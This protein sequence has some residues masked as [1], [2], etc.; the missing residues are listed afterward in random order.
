[1][2]DPEYETLTAEDKKH[3]TGVEACI[4]TEH[5]SSTAKLYYMALPRLL[6]LAQ[7]AWSLQSNKLYPSFADHVLP[8]HLERFDRSGINYRV[9]AATEPIDTTIMASTYTLKASVPFA[10][11]KVFYT[12]NNKFPAEADHLYTAQVNIQVPRGKKI[13]IKTVVI[14]PAGRRSVVTRTV[15]DASLP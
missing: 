11:A 7:T 2:I 6:G 10:G 13:I 15:I 3:I 14:T 12:L 4:W 5:I 9:P 1:M 8:V